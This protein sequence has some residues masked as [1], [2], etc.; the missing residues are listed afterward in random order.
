M[1]ISSAMNAGVAGL[2]VN[3]SKLATIADN[4][5][6]SKTYGYKRV[7]ADF[8][9]MALPE[10][11][12]KYTAGGV[13]V[14]TY[15][16]V[17][18]QG[19][20]ISTANS[21]DIAV[22]GRGML[23]VSSAA[24][25]GAGPGP[26]P[27]MMT[28]TG[29]FRPD[30][31]GILRTESGLVLL[32]WPAAPDGTVPPQSRDSSAGLLPVDVTHNQFAAD[33]TTKIGLG[34][35][36]P[37]NATAAGGSGDSME[38][39]LEY[40]DNL[41]STQT[42]TAVFTPQVPVAGQSNL[43]TLEIID[44]ATGTAPIAEFTV[45]FDAT[46]GLGG[47]ILSVAPVFGG[48]YNIATGEID[49]TFDRGP[50]TI[51]VGAPGASTGLTQLSD[52]F[53]PISLSKNGAPTGNVTSVEIDSNG[54]VSANYDSGYSRVIFQVPLVDVANPNALDP[55]MGQSFTATRDSGQFF[56]WN[57]G[58]GPT[59]AT[60]GYA[61]EESTTDIAGE[62]TALIQTQR[63]YASNAKIIQTVDEM[64]QET[65]NIKR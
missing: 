22:G 40:F 8:T 30:S 16:E 61:L 7:D 21:T 32:G 35:N 25:V 15:R 48:S 2:N 4:I 53:A 50:V 43:W 23:P 12:G 26:Y 42:M 62:L 6:N 10:Q 31:N 41:G 38:I 65:T 57:A 5:A 46:T 64:L 49:V 36:L 34:I 45:Q 51:S 1:T 11:S 17:T 3:A 60:I 59:G 20:L 24:A 37:A 52:Q 47:S 54:I 14:S 33:P 58:D 18:A 9:A 63:A 19:A 28:A 29:S 44:L 39:S 55:S 56:L 13:R 27:L